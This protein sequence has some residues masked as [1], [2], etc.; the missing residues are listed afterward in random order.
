MSISN[1]NKLHSNLK[2]LLRASPILANTQISF[3]TSFG[4]ILTIQLDGTHIVHYAQ[5]KIPNLT[6]PQT[7]FWKYGDDA[8]IDCTLA[9]PDYIWADVANEFERIQEKRIIDTEEVKPQ[10]A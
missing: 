8:F 2:D 3:L 6:L 7:M 9:L 1:I 5:N 10:I 4:E